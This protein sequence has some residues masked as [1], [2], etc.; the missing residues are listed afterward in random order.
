MRPARLGGGAFQLVIVRTQ[1]GLTRHFER[2]FQPES[3]K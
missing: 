3:A 1:Y 2:G